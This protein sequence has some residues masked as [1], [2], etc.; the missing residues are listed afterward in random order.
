MIYTLDVAREDRT[1]SKVVMA[2]YDCSQTCSGCRER[3]DSYRTLAASA[4]DCHIMFVAGVRHVLLVRQARA[5]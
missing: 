4:V 1:Y 5:V 3:F 2:L